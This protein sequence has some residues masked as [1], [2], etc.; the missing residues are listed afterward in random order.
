MR[1]RTRPA[2]RCRTCQRRCPRAS[3]RRARGSPS[4]TAPLPVLASAQEL[5]RTTAPALL[6]AA[7]PRAPTSGRFSR[8]EARHLP[9]RTWAQYAAEVAR[10]RQGLRALGPQARRPHRHHGGRLRGLAD[11]PTSRPSRWAPSSTASIRRRRPRRSNTKCSDGGAV[12][13]HRRGPGVRRQDLAA[14]ST[15]CRSSAA[16]WWSTKRRCLPCA[17]P[18]LSTF[19]DMCARRAPT[20]DLGLARAARSTSSARSSPLSLSIPRARPAAPRARW[21]HAWQASGGDALGGRA[22]S[23]ARRQAAPHG[24]LPAALPRARP[25]YRRHPA[26]DS[27]QLVPH[28]GETRRGPARRRCSRR[29]RPCSFTVPR[30]LQK[31]RRRDPGRH[32]RQQRP[33]AFRLRARH[34]LRPWRKRAL[35]LAGKTEA[36]DAAVRL[37][38]ARLSCSAHPQQDRLRPA[39]ARASAAA[40]R[41]PAETMASLWQMLG[42][43]VVEMYGQTETAGGIIAGQRGPFAPTRR[44]RHRCPRASR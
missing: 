32:R 17:T 5:R 10:C 30:Y 9:G 18:S 23:H 36:R 44:R 21:C 39:R 6:L 20:P 7:R 40:R 29:P 42:V 24:R 15:G 4:C 12:L 11:L 1:R 8:Q 43:N 27:P 38:L 22:L 31:L 2:R 35:A 26:A 13:S 3:E 41:C 16:C 33:E 34:G 25:R 14:S 37:G 19:A 28:I